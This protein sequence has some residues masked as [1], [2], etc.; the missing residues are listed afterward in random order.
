MP[1][2]EYI[3][4]ADLNHR[5]KWYVVTVGR[6]IGIWPEWLDMVG[7]ISEVP[8][9]EH[10]SFKTRADADAHYRARRDAGVVRVVPW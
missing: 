1:S 4:P 7:Y 8:G 2:D 5:G 10:K 3:A 9:S 6:R